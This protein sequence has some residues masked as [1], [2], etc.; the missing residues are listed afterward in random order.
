MPYPPRCKGDKQSL[1]ASRATG[2]TGGE[3]GSQL[4]AVRGLATWL[5]AAA[6]KQW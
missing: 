5:P 6:H 1:Q 2:A 4:L 3:A